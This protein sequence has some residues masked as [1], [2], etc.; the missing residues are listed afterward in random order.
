MSLANYMFDIQWSLKLINE[1]EK[2]HKSN[3]I[4]MAKSCV[5]RIREMLETYGRLGYEGQF[6]NLKVL[7]YALENGLD[8]TEQIKTVRNDLNNRSK[9]Y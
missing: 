9:K 8:P 5:Q 3:Q 2:F 6:E 7:E 4:F 1:I